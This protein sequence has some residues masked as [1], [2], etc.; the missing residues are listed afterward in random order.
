MTQF[1]TRKNG[2]K[3]PIKTRYTPEEGITGM[4]ET[5]REMEKKV[6]SKTISVSSRYYEQNQDKKAGDMLKGLRQA[7]P[8]GYRIAFNKLSKEYGTA[9]VEKSMRT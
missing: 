1:R 6:T 7:S 4:G 8:I 2:R 5:V 3:Y 9:R